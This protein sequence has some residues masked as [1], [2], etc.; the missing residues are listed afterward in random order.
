MKFSQLDA[1]PSLVKALVGMV[2][3]GKVPHAIIFH[4]DDGG[5]AFPLCT[6]FLQYLY[7]QDHR[8][9]D[10][11]EECP[12]CNKIGKFIHADV[13]FIFPVSQPKNSSSKTPKISADFAVSFRSLASSNP[14]FS[15]SELYAALGFE[16]KN[17]N[18]SVREASVLLDTLSLSALE[19]GFSTAVIYLPEKLGAAAANK[20]LKIIE[21]PPRKTQFLLI[22]H[23]PDAILPTIKSRCQYFRLQPRTYGCARPDF[24]TPESFDALMDALVSRDLVSVLEVM[25]SNVEKLSSRESSKAFCN[26]ANWRLRQIFLAQWGMTPAEDDSVLRWSAALPKTF[27]RAA[28]SLFDRAYM[29]TERN[30]NVKIL[31][32]DLANRLFRLI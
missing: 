17:T 32:T 22:T 26:F 8:T 9:G 13:H 10:S 15:E 6:A 23:K 28:A 5:G 3:S 24:D 4:E 2:D 30:V 11:C 20:L 29:L 21:E 18:I 1:D 16:G 7:C 25:D 12:Q 27:P 31:Y 19:G 14:S